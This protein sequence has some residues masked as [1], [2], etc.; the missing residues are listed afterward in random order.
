MERPCEALVNCILASV[1]DPF[2]IRPSAGV[3]GR[4][5]IVTLPGGDIEDL[6]RAITHLVTLAPD[7]MQLLTLLKTGHV[8]ASQTLSLAVT[9]RCVIWYYTVSRLI[10]IALLTALFLLR[11]IQHRIKFHRT[12]HLRS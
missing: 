6:R 2:F 3:V 5:L 10:L 12:Y 1:Q 11:P 9:S 7:L 4:T 8:A